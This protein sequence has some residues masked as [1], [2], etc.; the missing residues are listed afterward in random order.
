MESEIEDIGKCMA[1]LPMKTE[2][3][4]LVKPEK[5]PGIFLNKLPVLEVTLEDKTKSA[6]SVIL[7]VC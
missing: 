1:W 5:A 6:T 3:F 4:K 7:N 2:T